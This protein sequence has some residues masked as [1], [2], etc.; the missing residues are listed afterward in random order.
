MKQ[1]ASRKM[2]LLKICVYIGKQEGNTKQLISSH[3]HSVT[4]QKIKFF[5]TTA[6]RT[7]NPTINT[8][9]QQKLF[10]FNRKLNIEY[11]SFISLRN[12]PRKES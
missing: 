9:T 11:S 1:V 10:T 7:S 6:V 12:K 2:H 5:I 8:N 4:S 3:W